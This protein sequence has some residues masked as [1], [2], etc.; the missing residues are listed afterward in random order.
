M[1][2]EHD[3]L[4]VYERDLQ[5]ARMIQ[6]DFLPEK[7][8]QPLGWEIA[9]RFQPARLV[10]GDFYDAFLLA[11]NRV[12]IVIADV[13][14]K[15]VGAAL[16]MSL[17][18]SLIRAF[19]LQNYNLSWLDTLTDAPSTASKS[20][21]ERRTPAPTIGTTALKNAVHLTNNYIANNH[22]RINMF[23]T[24]FFGVLHPTT[25]LLNYVNGG[26]ESPV[27]LGANGVKARLKP[28]GPAVGIF[29]DRE[30]GIQQVQLE[31]G[32]ILVAYTDGVTDARNP[33]GQ[34]FGES[35]FLALLQPDSAT[36]LLDRIEVNVNA[37]I[38]DADQFDDI[39]LLA[40]QR[41]K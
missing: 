5:L 32:D 35:K 23:A 22:S 21:K 2:T 7:L 4:L 24:L 34:F 38:A 31:P 17:F 41:L 9:A 39:T 20:T 37:H 40:V 25:G 30:F 28:T 33:S 27:I 14:D 18:R 12:G 16:F 3:L 36:N 19:A 1:K 8:P 10:A 26:H 15:G 29:P 11:N 6:A 13:C